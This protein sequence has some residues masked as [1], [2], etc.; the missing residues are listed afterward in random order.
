MWA[1]LTRKHSQ[2]T[3]LTAGSTEQDPTA[4]SAPLT[5]PAGQYSINLRVSREDVASHWDNEYPAMVWENSRLSI[6]G[7]GVPEGRLRLALRLLLAAP[8]CVWE[9]VRWNLVWRSL[10]QP[11]VTRDALLLVWTFTLLADLML[12][13]LVGR[14]SDGMRSRLGRRK[15]LLVAAAVLGALAAA[16]VP[17]APQLCAFTFLAFAACSPLFLVG[18]GSLL[19][20][21]TPLH[22]CRTS[23]LAGTEAARAAGSLI[24]I[25]LPLA[26]GVEPADATSRL[27]AALLSILL[28]ASAGLLAALVPERSVELLRDPHP[29]RG[30]A[31]DV[32]SVTL[33]RMFRPV[34]T[35]EACLELAAAATLLIGVAASHS[36]PVEGGVEEGGVEEEEGAAIWRPDQ[37][38]HRGLALFFAGR[39]VALPAWH[40]AAWCCGVFSA[41]IARKLVALPAAYAV[42]AFTLFSPH[43]PSLYE[44]QGVWLAG[45][46]VTALGAAWSGGF[47]VHCL[48]ASAVDYDHLLTGERREGTYEA[49]R[50]ALPRLIVACVATPLLL[51]AHEPC[52]AGSDCYDRLLRGDS[53]ATPILLATSLA[54]AICAAAALACYPARAS[55]QRA[56]VLVAAVGRHVGIAAAHDPL[57]GHELKPLADT[58]ADRSRAHELLL[59]FWPSEIAFAVRRGTAVALYALPLALCVLS[60]AAS[61]PA[62]HRVWRS[63]DGVELAGGGLGLCVGALSLCFNFSRLVAAWRLRR[64]GLVPTTE[65]L[66]AHLEMLQD[67]TGGSRVQRTSSRRA[68]TPAPVSRITIRSWLPVGRRARSSP[69]LARAAKTETEAVAVSVIEMTRT[70]RRRSS[71][72][73]AGGRRSYQAAV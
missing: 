3:S 73:G 19:V 67:F 6:T 21:V 37:L 66:T 27:L 38:A 61:T 26:L 70:P 49:V 63:R 42:C 28:L 60:L 69:P 68:R 31:A 14:W 59:Q 18:H 8:A 44:P 55:T 9:A 2:A 13:P 57:H 12:L 11:G 39:L 56:A 54:L 65:V 15:P 53:L 4:W 5:P 10:L 16:W 45:A 35:A 33:N 30:L 36:L 7:G 34:L 64:E 32:V 52:L 71:H 43:A 50:R 40:A 29:P 46:A 24:G 48:A 23:L 1:S 72:G 17:D 51:L 47:G 58:A 22:H 25:G 41:A 62:H 20:E